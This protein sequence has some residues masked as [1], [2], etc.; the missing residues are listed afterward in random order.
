MASV[1]SIADFFYKCMCLIQHYI[2]LED[3]CLIKKNG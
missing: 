3:F 1:F 2:R